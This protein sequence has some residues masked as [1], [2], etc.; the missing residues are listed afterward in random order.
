MNKYIIIPVLFLLLYSAANASTIEV[1]KGKKYTTISS[2]ID[3]A[4]SGDVI[5]INPGN[6]AE[7][8]IKIN[9]RIH[10]QGINWPVV[11][12]KNKTQILLVEANG[13]TIEGLDLRNCGYSSTYDWA[14]I[15]VINSTHVNIR[16]NKLFD[17]AF[18]INLQNTSF[19]RIENNIVKGKATSEIESGNAIHC[20]KSNHIRIIGNEL[21][22]HR[23]G[24]YFEF[25]TFSFIQNNNSYKN[26]RY[27]LHFMFSNDDIYFNNTFRANGSG[28]A[29][30][31]SRNVSMMWNHF[32]E[33]WGSAA[34][35]I[36]L[37]EI[38]G[39]KIERNNF[40][41][42]TVG[43]YMEGTN[44][45]DVFNNNFKANGWA[46]RIQSSCNNNQVFNNNFLANTFD[47]GTNGTMQLNKFHE[48]Y[49]DKY[50]GYDLDKNNIGDVQYQ[51][52]SLYSM[53]V[54]KIPAA[55][56]LLRSF[57][58]TIMDKAERVVPSITPI[59]LKDERPLM[60]PL[61]L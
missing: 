29:V 13:V 45:I 16:N 28:V 31:F 26:I 15:K 10:L 22:G 56:I 9:K 57:M 61:P 19:C 34:Y 21:T 7:G 18:A 32:E 3:A 12:G 1:G 47:V 59:E 25:V 14:A 52:V 53:V 36:L 48:N 11:D 51:P 20:W 58:V 46:L 4:N 24:I 54:E 23:D 42:N 40:V 38:S 39:G 41:R 27:G 17:N 8:E 37:K 44:S 6:Y 33:N 2:A 35:G 5:K 55:S 30:M 50:E 43:V 60:K 49:W